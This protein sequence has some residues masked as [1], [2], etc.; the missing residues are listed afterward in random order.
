MFCY[1]HFIND[2][3]ICRGILCLDR[4]YENTPDECVYLGEGN[5]NDYEQYKGMKFYADT[6]IWE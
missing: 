3:N 6:G 4:Q 1:A 2:D 5:L